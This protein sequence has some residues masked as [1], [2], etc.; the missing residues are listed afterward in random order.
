MTGLS[1]L[2]VP[3]PTTIPLTEPFWN[4]AAKSEFIIQHC[5]SCDRHVFYPREICP[6]CWAN[7]LHWVPASGNGRLKS[8][9]VIHRPGHP[10]WAAVT[11]YTVGLV[12]LAEG[13]T[14]LS[15]ILG[16]DPAVGQALTFA[17]T[18]IGGRVLPC[19][20]ITKQTHE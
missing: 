4:A 15:H 2:K 14:M 8:F 13:P 10:G 3:G 6:H 11:P 17:P 20:Q 12:E 16:D 1:K 5:T 9:S 7:A 18:N 19:F